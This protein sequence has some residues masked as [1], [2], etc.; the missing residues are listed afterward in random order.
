MPPPLLEFDLRL[1][2]GTGAVLV[3][4]LL[5]AAVALQSQMATFASAAV[6]EGH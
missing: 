6:P 1:G 3:V 2:E 4:P 5:R